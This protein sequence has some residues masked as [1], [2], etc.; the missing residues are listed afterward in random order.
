MIEYILII[1]ELARAKY[2]TI[3]ENRRP[4]NYIWLKH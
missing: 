1:H 2:N 4:E 3:F